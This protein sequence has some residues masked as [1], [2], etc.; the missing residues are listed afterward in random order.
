MLFAPSPL[1]AL[2]NLKGVKMGNNMAGV[3]VVKFF[4]AVTVLCIAPFHFA[5]KTCASA[6]PPQ[7]SL[8]H[9]CDPAGV[10]I[11]AMWRSRIAD[12]Y[13]APH[14]VSRVRSGFRDDYEGGIVVCDKKL[15]Q[16]C[17]PPALNGLKN[18]K[19][20]KLGQKHSGCCSQKTRGFFTAQGAEGER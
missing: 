1:M 17:L 16:C 11:T 2:K 14:S 3:D 13:N 18:V 15:P 9:I 19:G 4:R 5:A 7:L 10:G 20:V 12:R 8:L 6:I